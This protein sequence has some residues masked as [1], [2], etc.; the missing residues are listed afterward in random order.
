MNTDKNRVVEPQR[1]VDPRRKERKEK[2]KHKGTRNREIHVP[3]IQYPKGLDSR[4][5]GNDRKNRIYGPFIITDL[6]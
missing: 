6:T 1:V 5:R 2:P 3:E 4:F